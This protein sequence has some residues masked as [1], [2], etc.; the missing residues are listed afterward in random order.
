MP[1][2]KK[3]KL[4][5]PKKGSAE[6]KAWAE[7]MQKARAKKKPLTESQKKHKKLYG[8]LEYGRIW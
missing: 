7:A 2:T 8:K 6:A 3:T 5:Y 1:Y 4:Y